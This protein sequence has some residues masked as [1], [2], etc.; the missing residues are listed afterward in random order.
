[1]LQRLLGETTRHSRP[2][3]VEGAH[4]MM[5]KMSA[6]DVA[7]VQRGMA[8]RPDSISTLKTIAVPTLIITGDEDTMTGLPE[9][10][11][12]KQHIAGAQ[13]KVVAKAGHYS[14]WEQPEEVGK[15]LRQF[16][17]STVRG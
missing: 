15:M 10:E 9:A 2:D 17:D 14:P 8:D 4:R 1:M 5:R 11:V 3:L 7:G 13:M 6:E 16:L 12:M